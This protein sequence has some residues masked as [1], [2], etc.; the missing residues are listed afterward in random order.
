MNSK[1][2]RPLLRR[3]KY[4]I[5]RRLNLGSSQWG[6]KRPINRENFDQQRA[7]VFDRAALVWQA[8]QRHYAVDAILIKASATQ[9]GFGKRGLPDYGLRSFIAG[10]LCVHCVEGDHT[11]I[12]KGD[13][14]VAVA[15]IIQSVEGGLV[16]PS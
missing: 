6:D 4:F 12:L 2:F 8:T 1:N 5:K 10:K 13:A 15:N 11:G 3:I 14:V 9:F 16:E 7:R